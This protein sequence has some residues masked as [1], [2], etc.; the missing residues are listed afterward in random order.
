M[1]PVSALI[2]ELRGTLPS[3]TEQTRQRI[4]LLLPRLP[5][6]LAFVLL[7]L[8]AGWAGGMWAARPSPQGEVPPTPKDASTASTIGEVTKPRAPQEGVSPASRE[9]SS[10]EVTKPRVSQ[11]GVSPTSRETTVGQGERRSGGKVYLGIRGKAF[12]QGEV[13]GVKISAVFPGSPAA[14]AGLRSDRDPAPA[15]LRRSSGST[16]HIIVGAN[17]RAIRSEEDMSRLLALSSPGSVVKFLVTSDDGNS[18][19]VIP[20]TLGDTPET[21]PKVEAS[22]EERIRNPSPPGEA[23][24]KE[25]EE[26]VFRAVN[27]A[28]AEKGLPLLQENPQLQ[29]VARRHSEDMAARHFFGHL[30]PDGRDVVD[31]LRAQGI[32]EFTAAGENIF[33]GKKVADPAQMAVREWLNN[34]SHRGNLLN[35]RYTSGGVGISQG[36]KEAIYVTQVYLER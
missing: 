23:S 28:R 13:S 20:V 22:A 17:G 3:R 27:Q 7:A 36:E 34:P 16:G 4:K 29:Q 19:E 21:S 33:S 32:E 6:L 30:N 8:G 18:Y 14:K 24:A 31:R 5:A 11:A 26:E 12:H 15:Y 9:T 2:E 25:I 1:R 35:P 10:G